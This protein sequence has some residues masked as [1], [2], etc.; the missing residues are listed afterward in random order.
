MVLLLTQTFW[1]GQFTAFQPVYS[2]IFSTFRCI[3][4]H[5]S[6][7]DLSSV[8]LPPSFPLVHLPASCDMIFQDAVWVTSYPACCLNTITKHQIKQQKEIAGNLLTCLTSLIKICGPAKITKSRLEPLILH[9]IVHMCEDRILYFCTVTV[10]SKSLNSV[11]R[12]HSKTTKNASN[13]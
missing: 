6:R 11:D 10:Y 7:Y 1:C 12:H 4:Q 13:I 2:L 3:P 9:W 5:Y 8:T